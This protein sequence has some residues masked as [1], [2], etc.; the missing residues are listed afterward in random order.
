MILSSLFYTINITKGQL[1]I[2]HILDRMII[3]F[4]MI[5][6]SLFIFSF[7]QQLTR[8]VDYREIWACTD[9][10]LAGQHRKKLYW[11]AI[12]FYR[13]AKECEHYNVLCWNSMNESFLWISFRPIERSLLEIFLFTFSML[14][15][16][17]LMMMRSF[18]GNAILSFLDYRYDS[19]SDN[20]EFGQ[21]SFSKKLE[22]TFQ[23]IRLCHSLEISGV[24]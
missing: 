1:I 3:F 14:V 7:Y 20:D 23:Q 10:F 11:L 13:P 22:N 12:L 18:W 15:L 24:S 8:E 16:D 17:T 9:Y 19:F 5:R 21:N 2:C 4:E 6:Y